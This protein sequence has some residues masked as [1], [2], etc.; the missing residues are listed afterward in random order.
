MNAIAADQGAETILAGLPGIREADL[1]IANLESVATARAATGVEKSRTV[2]F[3]F[4]ARPETLNVLA[5]SGIDAVS[6]ANNHAGDYGP[7]ALFEQN[8]LLDAIGVAH[9]GSGMTRSDACAPIYLDAGSGLRVAFFSADATEPQFAATPDGPGTCHL[10]I[11]DL[12]SWSA[13]FADA[14]A[15]ARGQAHAVLV[16]VHWGS[17]WVSSPSEAKRRLGQHLIELG[18]DVIVGANAHQ[19]QG[20]ERHEGGVVLHDLAHAAAPFPEPAES[21]TFTLSLTEDGVSSV[22]IDPFVTQRN[23]ARAATPAERISILEHMA[24]MSAELGTSLED[25]RIELAPPDRAD[26]PAVPPDLVSPNP[27]P[28]G[29][30]ATAP[31]EGCIVPEVPSTASIEPTRLGPLVLVGVETLTDRQYLPGLVRLITYWSI[32]D[33]LSDDLQIAPHGIP[34]GIDLDQW[35]SEHDPCDWAW[36]TSRW[37]PGAIYRDLALLRPPS[38]ILTAPGAALQVSGAHGS[39]D[40]TVG[41]VRDGVELA[42]SNPIGQ[43]ELGVPLGVQIAALAALAGIGIAAAGALLRRRRADRADGQRG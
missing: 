3:Y 9:A 4:R 27:R 41:V 32:D 1:A 19:L 12:D 38:E 23:G 17:N 7:D 36:P 29:L 2:P 15:E 14:I 24:A 30:E 6:T 13:A 25:G 8:K 20:V 31:P 10:A 37:T 26:A 22:Q 35:A 42:R 5:A 16:S 18:A 43:V 39:L 11:D 34:E 21:A 33:P 28:A 40:I